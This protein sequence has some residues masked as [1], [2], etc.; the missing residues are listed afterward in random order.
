MRTMKC[1][2]LIGHTPFDS[3]ALRAMIDAAAEGKTIEIA[4]YHKLAL[5][6]K[7]RNLLPEHAFYAAGNEV[8]KMFIN[9]R[10][11]YRERLIEV[12]SLVLREEKP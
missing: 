1:G 2:E 7:T 3:V 5:G 12:S 4:T 10:P 9:F 11:G 8:D 6:L